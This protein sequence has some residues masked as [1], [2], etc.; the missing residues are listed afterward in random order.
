LK[1]ANSL[2][3]WLGCIAH[4]VLF[5]GVCFRIIQGDFLNDP[6]YAYLLNGLNILRLHGPAQIDHPGTTVQLIAGF[7]FS[8]A[9]PNSV[10]RLD[11][12]GR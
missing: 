5:V 6:D 2:L 4:D 11:L 1:N 3:R 7:G 12:S 9:D 10:R 8:L